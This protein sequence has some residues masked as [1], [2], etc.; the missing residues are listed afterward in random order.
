MKVS[1]F[2]S[3]L[4]TSPKYIKDVSFFLDR[5]KTGTSKKT[6]EDIRK[7]LNK[8]ERNILKKQLPVVCF[9]GHFINRSKIGLKKASGLMIL[10]FDDLEN[11][12]KFKNDII[13]DEYVFSAFYSPSGDV[14]VLYRIIE[15][16]DDSHFKQVFEQIKE[17]YPLLD[18]S[19]KDVSRACYESYDP[20]IYIN[21]DAKIF[22][23]EIRIL[24]HEDELIG[25]ITNIPITDKDD[26]ANRL[27]KWFS[28]K[29]NR[30]QRNNSL[31]KL[32]SA[33]N[34]FGV[35]KHTALMYCG[36]YSEK[37]FDEKEI[38][39][40]VESAYKKTTQFGTKNF[41]D[42]TK[43][44]KLSNMVLAGKNQN[45]IK[46]EFKDIPEEKLLDEI[47]LIK[48]TIELDKFWEHDER[49]KVVINAYKFK[50]YLESLNNYKYYPIGNNKAFVFITKDENFLQDINEFQIKDEIM[51]N[52]LSKNEIEV[53]NEIAENTR[54]FTPSYLSMIET[55]D[56][57]IEKDGKDYAML[58]FKNKA[59]K[60]YKDYYEVYDYSELKNHIWKNQV[61]NRD[62][63]EADHHESM[64]RSFLWLISGKEVERYNTM[65]SVIGYLLHSYKTSANNKAIILNDEIISDN[66][67][68][69]SG[70]GLITNSIGQM[71][72]LSTIDGK[73]F[74]FGKSF[75]YQTVS[76]DCQ[77]LAFDD[78][79]KNFDFEKLFSLIT[80]GITIEY[81]NQGAIKL[82]VHESP[83]VLISTNYTIKA[84]GG[85]FT[86]RMFE[87]ELSS[88]FGAEHTP[89]DEF[90]C[91]FFEDWSEI[92]WA[93][94]DHFMINCLHY[95]LENG[96]V[97]YE[98]KN[99]K[100]RKLRNNTSPE[101]IQWMDDKDLY[102]QQKIYY[103]EWHVDFI[104]DNEDFTWIKQR[105]FN[106][107]LKMYLD[108]KNIKFEEKAS[109]SKRYYELLSDFLINKDK[110]AENNIPF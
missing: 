14:K 31:Y 90:G 13:K 11:P 49:G 59:I 63:I 24:P 57:Q 98:H 94:F 52:V 29:Y 53:F 9:N 21:L 105:T 22:I 65:K 72:K 109:N 39:S 40:I 110:N 8:E 102:N 38:I 92:E 74:D 107:W 87:V 88:F 10:D 33:F 44:Q 69:G 20:D 17:I 45:E 7:S 70:K 67:N 66:P 18:D 30:T 37:G 62:F 68:G 85:S 35:N 81:K 48:K 1:F 82:P 3:I 106:E 100:I 61:I 4:N 2:S 46:K 79:K 12:E 56:V 16:E 50:L 108:D 97:N 34:D 80:E 93:R 42:K 76:T 6:V 25:H 78:V 99:L 95:F 89:Y 32:A 77:V 83:K 96:L 91:M 75:A 55:A 26:V 73:T 54:L 41:E 104:K 84:R 58:Y 103:K 28:T 27:V 86:R 51:K 71:K 43:I 60:V 19:G 15:V 5:I 47:N 23:P 36:K 101:F 64:F